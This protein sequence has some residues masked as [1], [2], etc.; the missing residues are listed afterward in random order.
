MGGIAI[1]PPPGPP[2]RL[3]STTM[4][5][6]GH[7]LRENPPAT[8]R[9]YLHGSQVRVG[10]R[11][12]PLRPLA[13]PGRRMMFS[14]GVREYEELMKNGHSLMKK[15]PQCLARREPGSPLRLM[16]VKDVMPVIVSD[17]PDGVPGGH[18]SV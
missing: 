9:G 7:D 16:S 17:L 6:Y 4:R 3:P 2:R 8:I 18:H 12:C 1:V 13:Q 5:G 10:Q 11:E 14:S 15:P